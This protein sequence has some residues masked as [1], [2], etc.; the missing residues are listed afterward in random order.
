[1]VL[2]HN[3][4]SLSDIEAL[5]AQVPMFPYSV[6]QLIELAHEEHF[7]DEVVNFYKKFPKDEIFEDADDLIARTEHI[8]IMRHEEVNQSGRFL[9]DFDED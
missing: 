4:P 8:Q 5:V 2:S 7:P 9:D 3:Q 1:M 6:K